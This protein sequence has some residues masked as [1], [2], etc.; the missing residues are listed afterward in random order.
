MNNHSQRR[1]PH[2]WFLISG[3]ILFT[4]LIYQCDQP[5]LVVKE[6]KDSFTIEDQKVIGQTMED[7]LLKMSDT[8]PILRKDQNRCAYD[9]IEILFNTLLNTSVVQNRKT[10]DWELHIIDND[11]IKN[12]F[13]LPG[14]HLYVYSGLMKYLQS[15]SELVAVLGNEIAYADQELTLN[16]LR[17]EHGNVTISD[18]SSGKKVKNLEE[19]LSDLPYLQYK[20]ETVFNADAVSISLI[21]PFQYDANSLKRFIEKAEESNIEWIRSKGGSLD[22][23]LESLNNLSASCGAD[24]ST[25]EERYQSFKNTCLP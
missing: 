10:F 14:G 6:D 19:I 24:E 21:C 16:A 11:E 13:I 15:E 22:K 17:A 9:R 20:E 5:E 12:S 23:R 2:N 1:L 7:Q 3:L 18:L 25:F 8:Y 4:L